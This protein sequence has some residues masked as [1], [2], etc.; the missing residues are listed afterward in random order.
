MTI[1][2]P[3]ANTGQPTLPLF[4]HQPPVTFVSSTLFTV[5]A[6]ETINEFI[7][8]E[9]TKASVLSWWNDVRDLWGWKA[10]LFR[11]YFS[12][13]RNGERFTPCYVRN[14]IEGSMEVC[15]VWWC[16]LDQAFFSHFD[17]IPRSFFLIRAWVLPRWKKS[18]INARWGRTPWFSFVW[19]VS[20]YVNISIVLLVEHCRFCYVCKPTKVKLLLSW[21]TFD[22]S[23]VF[24]SIEYQY[25]FVIYTPP[26]VSLLLEV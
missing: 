20:R 10:Q 14:D 6:D 3:P 22:V 1:G 23:S 11:K 13:P 26:L 9:W 12:L 25:F 17:R 19:I 21:Q 15:Y 4:Y 2:R 5:L 18:G 16:L 24:C 8:L 7:I